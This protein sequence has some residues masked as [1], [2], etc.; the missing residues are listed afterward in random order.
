MTMYTLS[1]QLSLGIHR[2]LV[3]GPVSDT[4]IHGGSSP[5]H[6]TAQ[7]NAYHLSAMDPPP[8][9][10]NT[11]GC[12]SH[13]YGGSTIQLSKRVYFKYRIFKYKLL[14]IQT[15]SNLELLPVLSKI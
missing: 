13:G 3:P 12:K 11:V 4:Q 7:N 2:G 15:S 10:E 14:Q 8:E 6:R 9:R 5:L 1:F